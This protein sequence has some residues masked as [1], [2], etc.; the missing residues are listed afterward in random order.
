MT[1][2][3]NF[4]RSRKMVTIVWVLGILVVW[5]IFAFIVQETKRTPIN[6]LPHVWQIVG[7]F[8]SDNKV[9]GQLTMAQ[10]IAQSCSET[11]LRAVVGFL[12]GTFVGYILALLMNLSGVV[13]KI[14]FPYLML[15]QMIPILGMAP[16][17]LAITGD[18]NKSRIMMICDEVMAGWGRTGKMFAFENFG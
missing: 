6:V 10:L 9:S 7:S 13:E 1:R 3:K 12:I 14:A 11:L 2:I 8:F 16:I 15:I 17:I 18:I 5:E 4:L